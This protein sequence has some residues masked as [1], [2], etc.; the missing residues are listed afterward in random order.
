MGDFEGSILIFQ[1]PYFWCDLHPNT[2]SA[3]HYHV[4]TP[5]LSAR[6]A[7][8]VKYYIP[9]S[10]FLSHKIFYLSQ[11]STFSAVLYAHSWASSGFTPFLSGLNLKKPELQSRIIS[12]NSLIHFLLWYLPF[13]ILLLNQ[14]AFFTPTPVSLNIKERKDGSFSKWY[15]YSLI[16]FL[17]GK[18]IMLRPDLTLYI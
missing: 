4:H 9:K 14:S 8:P 1:N 12:L 5:L 6:L 2:T 15:W 3:I 16:C 11:I 7:P 10:Y 13:K 18:I 17:P